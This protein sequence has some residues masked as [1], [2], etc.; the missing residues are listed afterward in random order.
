MNEHFGADDTGV[1]DGRFTCFQKN[2]KD[3]RLLDS[4]ILT[5]PIKQ[6]KQAFTPI[7]KALADSLSNTR[8]TIE[9]NFGYHKARFRSQAG[10]K[11]KQCI[12][13]CPQW[14]H[15]EVANSFAL[16]NIHCFPELLDLPEFD[17]N[18]SFFEVD[19]EEDIEEPDN[20]LDELL[21]NEVPDDV[22]DL[23]AEMNER[24]R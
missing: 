13:A 20:V 24:K 7:H 10:S 16:E 8:N 1:G 22:A 23:V 11:G 15:S 6:R 9:L 2:R 18:H 4:S 17:S 5:R 12:P 3:R 21:D 19:P 14:A